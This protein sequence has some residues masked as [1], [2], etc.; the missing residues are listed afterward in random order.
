M[1]TPLKQTSPA[2]PWIAVDLSDM[3]SAAHIYDEKFQNTC[4]MLLTV[5]VFGSFPLVTMNES[6]M[7]QWTC[8]RCLGSTSQWWLKPQPEST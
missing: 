2:L 4:L 1:G 3:M 7:S 6:V 8:L 5:Y